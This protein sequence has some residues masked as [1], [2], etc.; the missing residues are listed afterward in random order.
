MGLGLPR[1][2]KSYPATTS[3]GEPAGSRQK[4]TNTPS[5]PPT[6]QGSREQQTHQEHI[7]AGNK[8]EA[9]RFGKTNQKED[10][11]KNTAY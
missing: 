1:G 2:R 8:A 7:T 4:S 5:G 10:T 6:K 9:E 3:T 11:P